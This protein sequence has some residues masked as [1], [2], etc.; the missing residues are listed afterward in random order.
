MVVGTGFA[1]WKSWTPSEVV[2]KS[3]KATLNGLTSGTPY[4][5]VTGGRVMD[6]NNYPYLTG[7]SLTGNALTNTSLTDKYIPFYSGNVHNLKNSN[8]YI[9]GTETIVSG[10]ITITGWNAITFTEGKELRVNM[11]VENWLVVQSAFESANVWIWHWVLRSMYNN[12]QFNTAIGARAMWRLTS[13][14]RNTAVGWLALWGVTIGTDNTAVGIYASQNTRNG[15]YNVSVG[16]ESLFFNTGGSKNTALGMWAGEYSY[17]DKNVFLWHFADVAYATSWGITTGLNLTNAIAIGYNA[18]V[19]TSNMMQLGN[20][21]NWFISTNWNLGIGVAQPTQALTVSGNINVINGNIFD[22]ND[23]P[24]ITGVDLTNYATLSYLSNNYYDTTGIDNKLAAFAGWLIYKGTRDMSTW[25]FPIGMNTGDFYKISVSGTGGGEY[26]AVE[27]MMV[28]NKKKAGATS[29]GDWDRIVNTNNPEIDPI[30]SSEKSNYLTTGVTS[31][32]SNTNVPMWSGTKFFNTPM[33][34]SESGNLVNTNSNVNV[35]STWVIKIGN[36]NNYTTAFNMSLGFDINTALIGG[37]DFKNSNAGGQVR[38]MARNDQ[39]SYLI[40]SVAGSSAVNNFFWVQ[41]RDTATI[42][43]HWLA[44]DP[45]KKLA[46]GTFNAGDLLFGTN[47]IERIRVLSNGRVGIGTST[48]TNAL[49]VSGNINVTDGY[50]IYDGSGNAY[51]TGWALSWYITWISL[52]WNTYW[53]SNNILAPNIIGGYSFHAWFSSYA[54]WASSVAI[55]TYANAKGNYCTAVGINSYCSGSQSTAIGNQTYALWEFSLA[56]NTAT[57]QGRYATS[58]WFSSQ[59]SADFSTAIGNSIIAAAPYW[60]NLG[61]FNVW[62]STSVFE[63]GNGINSGTG[64]NN[65]LT[66]LSSGNVGIG[67]I[68]PQHKLDVDGDVWTTWW[69]YFGTKRRQ[70][71]SWDD[72]VIQA[73]TGWVWVE[74]WLFTP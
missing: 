53:P 36:W 8:M 20:T 62:L 59:A 19:W 41:W 38:F 71:L 61:S 67:T 12:A 1:I 55:G 3:I 43:S 27:D 34:Y 4:F 42:L 30:W 23:I 56:M 51:L 33:Q 50:N 32:L 11:G 35:P 64:R 17:G 7:D 24:Y 18:R 25:A 40:M 68:T 57:A 6:G 15:S 54:S 73:F 49:S 69:I 58:I 31:T 66:V 39:D 48:P 70:W 21:S 13:G 45:D 28:G 2:F 47:N 10:N 63:I 52:L 16:D 60:I 9:S 22:S 29:S 26:Y 44:A 14:L 37:L 65:A 46:I 72:L 74:K 5:Q